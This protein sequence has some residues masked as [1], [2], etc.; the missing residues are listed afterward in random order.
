MDHLVD[1]YI[2][3]VL[4]SMIV[5]KY[6]QEHHTKAHETFG[7]GLWV[8]MLTNLKMSEFIYEGNPV[9]VPVSCI[10]MFSTAAALPKLANQSSITCAHGVVVHNYMTLT[11][12]EGNNYQ[13]T[14]SSNLYTRTYTVENI[15]IKQ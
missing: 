9:Y 12:Q 10:P 5:S 1:K 14:V 11:G 2:Q 15:S 4:K 8:I 13:T 6:I 7:P 3:G